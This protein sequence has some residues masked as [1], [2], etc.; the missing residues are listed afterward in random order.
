MLRRA[1]RI[2]LIAALMVS[3]GLHWIVLQSAAWAGMMVRY[4][5]QEGSILTGIS[6][7]FDALH[8]CSMCGVVKQ[9]TQ[10]EQKDPQA[11]VAKKKLDLAVTALTRIVFTP[12]AP[13]AF[14]AP[15]DMDESMRREKPPSP[16][17]RRGT[18]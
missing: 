17:P 11:P 7:T 15:S 10:S 8:P 16:P 3:I 14:P 1:A 12:P 6:Q 2:L 13:V 4:S 18:A 9:G 5:L